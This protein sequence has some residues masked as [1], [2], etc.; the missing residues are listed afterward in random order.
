MFVFSPAKHKMRYLFTLIVFAFAKVLQAQP[1]VDFKTFQNYDFIAGEKILFEDN[2]Q[3]DQNGE[4]PAHWKLVSGQAVVNVIEGKPSL[5]LTEGN[6]AVV[7]PRM[8]TNKYLSDEF[9]LE[10]DFIYKKNSDGENS[11][12]IGIEFYY[13][14]PDVGY[15]FPFRVR[16]GSG[17]VVI[18]ELTKA[19]PEELTNTFFNKWHHAAIIYKKGTVKTYIDQYRVCVNPNL[20]QFK[21]DRI[22]FDGGGSETS[23]IVFTNVKLADGGGMNAIGK[24]FTDSKIVTHGINFDVNKASIKPESMGT[25]NG[26]VKIM[27]DNPEIKFEVGGHTDGDGD[28]VLNLKLSQERAE[29]VRTQLISMGIATA[30]LTA[31]GYGKTK[32]IADNA[33]WE[34]KATNRRVEFVKL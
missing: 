6:Y 17:D 3:E 16:F 1:V 25:L 5:L 21:P 18:D 12:A 23:P 28:E 7:T 2:F 29:A 10:F 34:G 19:Y 8:K 14:K 24:K 26:I 32:P 13:N 11:D 20:E 9:T 30:R 31:K 4:F 15:E 33:T 27:S 22:A